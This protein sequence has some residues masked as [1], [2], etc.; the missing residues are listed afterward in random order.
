M[1][2]GIA[3]PIQVKVVHRNRIFRECL[4]RVLCGDGRFQVA[5]VDHTDAGYL[6]A[7]AS[8]SPQVVLIDLSLPEQLALSLTQSL[9]EQEASPSR[10][11]L[12]T[13]AGTQDDLVECFAAGAQGCV[14]EES[15][16][17][18][19]REAIE[20]V[21]GGKSFCSHGL[22]HSVFHR[23]AQSAQESYRRVGDGAPSLTSR[24]LEIV[25]LIAEHLSNKQIAKRLSV[26]L[27]TVKNHVHNIVDK[28]QVTGRYEAV[29]YARKQGWLV[30]AKLAP[31]AHRR[32]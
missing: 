3:S 23:L 8:D 32:N 21:A 6:T 14:L 28:L 2:T 22:V 31:Q 30:P 24:E 25:R 4:A 17:E 11:I 10:I 27:Y 13:H 7:I 9:R 15:S 1:K 20:R 5:E 12:L 29:D 19:L 18:E 16:L 26:S